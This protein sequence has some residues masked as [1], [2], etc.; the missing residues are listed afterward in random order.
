MSSGLESNPRRDA[1]TVQR[2]STLDP[3]AAEPGATV[4]V[5]GVVRS[6]GPVR[7]L[8]G[9]SLTVAASEFVTITGPSGSGKST[10]LNLIGTLDRPDAGR[11][12]VDGRAVPDPRHAE[13]FRRR[14]VGFVFQDNLLLPYLS[15]RGN[16][17][18]ALLGAGVGRRERR[19]RGLQLL[20]EVGLAQRAHHLPSELSG[21]QRQAVA[22]ARA[23]ANDPRLLLADEPTGALDSESA[24][25]ALD[26]LASLRE[27]R[28]MTVLIVS[29]DPAV[30]ARADRVV[31]LVDGRVI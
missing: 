9:V 13:V 15:A 25:H 24:A 20:G 23:L 21:G 27:R 22:L 31:H 10:L 29:H 7:A 4:E 6:F 8:R 18:A 2:A 5:T 3:V 19:S 28:G 11:I 14:M 30:A 12:L 17:E 16:I 1:P 26:L